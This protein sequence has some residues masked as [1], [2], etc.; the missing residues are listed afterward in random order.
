MHA[1][2]AARAHKALIA[3]QAVWQQLISVAH[4]LIDD[5]PLCSFS[6]THQ[7]MDAETLTSSSSEG[8]ALLTQLRCSCTV[9]GAPLVGVE[10]S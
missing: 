9:G 7:N 8:Q 2:R 6:V 5:G 1:D 3:P 10:R 4:H